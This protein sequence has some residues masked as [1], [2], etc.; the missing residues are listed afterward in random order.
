M[1][2]SVEQEG[3]FGIKWYSSR[4]LKDDKEEGREEIPGYLKRVVIKGQGLAQGYDMC[5][6]LKFISLQQQGPDDWVICG[7]QGDT[8]ENLY[9]LLSQTPLGQLKQKLLMVAKLARIYT[10]TTHGNIKQMTFFF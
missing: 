4:N 3:G 7:H 2:S 9:D 5:K 6:A 8:N 1:F 10:L